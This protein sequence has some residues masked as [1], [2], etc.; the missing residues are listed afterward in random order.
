MIHL[1]LQVFQINTSPFVLTAVVMQWKLHNSFLIQISSKKINSMVVKFLGFAVFCLAIILWTDGKSLQSLFWV[2]LILNQA[3]RALSYLWMQ[4][5]SKPGNDYQHCVWHHNRHHSPAG[6]TLK[7]DFEREPRVITCFVMGNH[8]NFIIFLNW[9][10]P[11]DRPKFWSYWRFNCRWGH[12]PSP[13]AIYW[14]NK[15]AI[16]PFSKFALYRRIKTRRI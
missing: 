6:I 14:L 3:I 9:S 16:K 10:R 15:K 5:I 11:I 7:E 4:P 1:C 8:E 12:I 13:R 2:N